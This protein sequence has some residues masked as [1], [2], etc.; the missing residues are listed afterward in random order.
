[1]KRFDQVNVIPFIDI[2]L[3]LLAIVLTTATFISQEKLG[4]D[5]PR[6]QNTEPLSSDQSAEILIDADG[7]VRFDQQP[8]AFDALGS[9]LDELTPDT[10]IT[11]YVDQGTRFEHFVGVIDLLK[12]RQFDRLAIV[13]RRGG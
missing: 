2:M 9:R 13:T 10:G 11:L 7:A 4:L 12:A 3:V 5:L 8:I 6:A 1:M